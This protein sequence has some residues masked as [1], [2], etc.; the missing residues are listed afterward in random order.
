MVHYCQQLGFNSFCGKLLPDEGDSFTDMAG[1]VDC[2]DCIE[3]P[4]FPLPV[5]SSD[6]DILDAIFAQALG[7]C[8]VGELYG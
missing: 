4:Q 6:S 1:C 7:E 8:F 5:M 2:P 3:H